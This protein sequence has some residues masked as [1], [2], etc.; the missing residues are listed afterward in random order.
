MWCLVK[1]IRLTVPISC[2]E[3]ESYRGSDRSRNVE[4]ALIVPCLP[5]VADGI[6]IALRR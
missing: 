4:A 5:C 6:Q 2:I 3:S 1:I